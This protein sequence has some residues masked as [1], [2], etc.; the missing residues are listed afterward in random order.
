LSAPSPTA[1]QLTAPVGRLAALAAPSAVSASGAGA[2]SEVADLVQ[3]IESLIGQLERSRADLHDEVRRRTG[4]L[5]PPTGTRSARPN[6][7]ACFTSTR[8]WRV[9][10]S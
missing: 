9:S 1:A 5:E 8:R 4:D 10:T 3:Q 2:G 6:W 7:A